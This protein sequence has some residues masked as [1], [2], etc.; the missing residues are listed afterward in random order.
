LFILNIDLYVKAHEPQQLF[1]ELRAN[2]NVLRRLRPTQPDLVDA[3]ERNDMS[4]IKF[5]LANL[6]QDNR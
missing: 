4:M 3:I 6:N 1:N 5:L 2:P